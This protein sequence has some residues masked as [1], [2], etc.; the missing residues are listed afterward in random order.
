MLRAIASQLY[1]ISHASKPAS[2]EVTTCVPQI[3]REITAA[4]KESGPIQPLYM[5]NSEAEQELSRDYLAMAMK[6]TCPSF[7]NNA[8][9]NHS[10]HSYRMWGGLFVSKQTR[11]QRKHRLGCSLYTSLSKGSSKT[12]LTHI[13][14]RYMFS[15]FVAISLTQ[16]LSA[17][18]YSLSFGLRTC[19]VVETSPA[20]DIFA[21]AFTD[22]RSPLYGRI[23]RSLKDFEPRETTRMIV[24]QLR[25]VY[26]SGVAS[27]FDVDTEGNNIAHC[28]VEVS[29]FLPF[30]S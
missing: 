23:N 29:T 3:G 27:P 7:A 26:E 18:A 30:S 21:S 28:C 2:M 8:A 14:L 17:G 25:V 15:R 11:Q 24:Q 16:D 9:Y 1:T 5:R 6:C 12:T 20:F 19:N 22:Y 13:G 4:S 10:N